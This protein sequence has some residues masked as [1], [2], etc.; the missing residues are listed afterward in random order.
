MRPSTAPEMHGTVVERTRSNQTPPV[1]TREATP[2]RPIRQR[3]MLLK[4]PHD[5]TPSL[6]LSPDPL[7]STRDLLAEMD[8]LESRM[9]ACEEDVPRAR[10]VGVESGAPH[11]AADWDG[12]EWAEGG[13][14]VEESESGVVA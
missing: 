7:I 4:R 5:L 3:R 2:I 6:R 8:D 11:A 9:H 14:G 13:A 1:L 12:A 10:R